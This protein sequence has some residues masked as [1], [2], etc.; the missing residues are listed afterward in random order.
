MQR[1]AYP[2]FLRLR[3][4]GNVTLWQQL[5]RLVF[6]LVAL[7]AGFATGLSLIFLGYP[8][9]GIRWWVLLPL[10]FGVMNV[11]I[12]LTGLNP[13]WVLLFNVS[14]TT[15]FKFTKIKQPQVKKILWSRSIWLL[16]ISLVITVV[17]SVIFCAVPSKRL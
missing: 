14:E 8:P 2:K 13:L 1:Q 15:T 7:L 17:L 3:V 16:V 5:G 9:W 11:L 6:G 12:F 10:W 4:W